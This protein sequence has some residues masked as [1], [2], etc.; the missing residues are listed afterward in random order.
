MKKSARKSPKKSGRADP[1]NPKAAVL[2]IADCARRLG[3]TEQHVLNL[4]EEGKLPA[5][6]VGCYSRHYYRIPIEA[7]EDFLKRRASV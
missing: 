4:I 1:K 2:L 7:L 6:D 3:V 5:I